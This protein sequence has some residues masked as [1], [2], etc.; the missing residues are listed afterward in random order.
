MDFQIILVLIQS[1]ELPFIVSNVFISQFSRI[2]CVD[3]D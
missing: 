3:D 1:S 2:D